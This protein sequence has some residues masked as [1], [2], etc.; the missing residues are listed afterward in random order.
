MSKTSKIELDINKLSD[1]YIPVV[2]NIN[3]TGENIFKHNVDA[4]FSANIDYPKFSY[5][6]HHFIHQSKDKMEITEQFKGK[7]KVYYV[8]NQFERYVDDY[9]NDI[10]NISK[11]YFEIDPRPNILSRAFY[12]LWEILFMFDIV[13]VD[14]PNFI[15]A[16]LAEGPGSFI[17]A[18]MFFRDM[19]SKKGI[20][21]NDKYH[22]ITL[23]SEDLNKHVPPLEES[24]I[25]YY[26]KEK[27]ERF[28][29]HKTYP[30][31]IAGGSLD[32]DDGDLTNPKTINLFGGNFQK[33]KAHFVTADGGFNWKNENTQEQEAF[34]LILAQIITAI[35][36]QAKGGHFVCKF[37]ESFTTSTTKLIAILKTFYE[38][39]HAIKPLMSRQSNSEKYFVCMNFKEDKTNARNISVLENILKDALKNRNQNIVSLFPTFEMDSDFEATVIKLNTDI[40]N[41]QLVLINQM[42]DFI[43]KQNYRGD[44]YQTRR[45]MQIEAT[46]FWT[47]TFFPDADN[48][49]HHKKMLEKF[50]KDIETKNIE[51]KNRLEKKLS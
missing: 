14:K 21:K 8:L 20:T 3:D 9:D 32:K 36:I 15:S 30:K 4:K 17:Q 23:H 50:I 47:N 2:H 25:K 24:F 16:H 11:A 18:T 33:N 26:S 34:K 43:Q 12:K 38:E 29:Q 39:V 1:D 19:Y 44:T 31:E 41:R 6:F 22:A 7:K 45:D 40:S 48:F 51:R 28:V 5:G 35:K 37:F 46:K 49:V 42:V 13:Q 10:N 27:P